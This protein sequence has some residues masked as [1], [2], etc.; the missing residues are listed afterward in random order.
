M[1]VVTNLTSNRFLNIKEVVDPEYG[2]K[3]YQ[4]AERLGVDSVAFICFDPVKSY[5]LLNREYK[6]LLMNLFWGRLADLSIK[7][8]VLSKLS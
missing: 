1:R 7:I 5:F 2:V 3:G 4:F 6:H 8:R